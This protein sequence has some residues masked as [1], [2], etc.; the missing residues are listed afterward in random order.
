MQEAESARRLSALEARMGDMAAAVTQLGKA[1]AQATLLQQ[2][3]PWGGA[4]RGL[5]SADGRQGRAGSRWGAVLRAVL[6][7]LWMGSDRG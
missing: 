1:V 3:Q 2:Q 5:A 4:G 6:R 7:A